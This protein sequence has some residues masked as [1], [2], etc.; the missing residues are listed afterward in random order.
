MA[1]SLKFILEKIDVTDDEK[2]KVNLFL[3]KLSTVNK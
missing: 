1:N 2:S 3:K